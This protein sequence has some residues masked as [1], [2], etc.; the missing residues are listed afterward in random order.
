MKLRGSR[1]QALAEGSAREGSRW[2]R[3][4]RGCRRRAKGRVQSP[5]PRPAEPGGG[6]DWMATHSPGWWPEREA[7]NTMKGTVF[8]VS[9]PAAPVPSKP[10]LTL[11]LA[12][13]WGSP[14]CS[15]RRFRDPTIH[16]GGRSQEPQTLPLPLPAPRGPEHAGYVGEE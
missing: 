1:T 8:L 11:D 12:S 9:E 6:R 14:D 5:V 7:G 15:I 10:D 16:S 13:N 4:A 3:P 2:H